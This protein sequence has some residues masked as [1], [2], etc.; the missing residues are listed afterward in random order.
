MVGYALHCDFSESYEMSAASARP[1]T[2]A[3]RLFMTCPP[4]RQDLWGGEWLERGGVDHVISYRVYCS[5]LLPTV[6]AE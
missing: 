1:V 3:Q 4:E 2:S 6:S 5:L